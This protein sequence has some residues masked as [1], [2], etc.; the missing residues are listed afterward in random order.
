MNSASLAPKQPVAVSS[1]FLVAC[2]TSFVL[3]AAVLVLLS[4]TGNPQFRPE[5]LQPPLPIEV[6]LLPEDPPPPA[7]PLLRPLPASQRAIAP[8]RAVPPPEP[9]VTSVAAPADVPLPRQPVSMEAP[10]PPSAEE[11]QLAATYTLKNSKRYRYAWGEQVRSL[12][13]T[14]VEGPEQGDV[15]FRVEIAPDGHLVRLDTIWSTS[16][17]AERLVR[18]AMGRMPPLPPTPTGKPLVFEKTIS[19]QPHDRG[20]PPIYQYDCLPDPPGFHNP[21]V[22]NGGISRNS[23]PKEVPDDSGNEAAV[24][25]ENCANSLPRDTLEAVTADQER[26]LKTW[27]SLPLNGVK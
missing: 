19:F 27:G 9:G 12:M 2:A 14:V 6:S 11:W 21:F 5:H 26:Q 8:S 15:R 1:A 3:H 22:W 13:G 20:W 10:P 24:V 23:P 25:D 7:Q 4:I 17:T 18:E 16:D